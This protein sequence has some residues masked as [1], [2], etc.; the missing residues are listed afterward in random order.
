MKNRRK[1]FWRI[2]FGIAVLGCVACVLIV[3]RYYLSVLDSKT[4]YDSVREEVTINNETGVV[5][6]TESETAVEAET[7]LSSEAQRALLEQI[8][9]AEFTGTIEGD[10]TEIPEEVLTD[11]ENQPIDF[12]KLSEINS[13]LYAWIRIPNTSIDYPI[14]QHE[15]ENQSFYLHRDLYQN[16]Q[17][18]GCIYTEDSNS[19]DFSDP[20]TVI[21][22]HNMRNGTMFQNLHYFEDETFFEENEYIYIYTPDENLVYQVF[23]V[24]A[25]DDRDIMEAFDF[26]DDED[27]MEYFYSCLNP[28]S[29][30]ALVRDD[31]ELNLDSHVITLS[32]CIGD[33]TDERLLV[34]AVLVYES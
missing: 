28:R 34:Q 16:V 14:A 26:S 21:Y 23:A 18:A 30:D 24:Y 31:V 15:G 10:T 9:N 2:V 20:V 17:Y 4:V 25:Y 33:R 12:E 27:I 19:T 1:A 8:V 22:G 11:M 13:E 6:E 7:E 3:G 32:T 29:M 5:V